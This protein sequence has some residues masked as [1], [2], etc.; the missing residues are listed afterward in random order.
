MRLDLLYFIDHDLEDAVPDHSTIC[1]TRQRI[2]KEVFEEVFNHILKLC[3][4]SGL[5]GGSIQSIDSAY[6]IEMHRAAD[7]VWGTSDGVN[8]RCGRGRNA[9]LDRMA[10][11]KLVDR[12]PRDYLEEILDQDL[13]EDVTLEDQIKRVTKAQKNLTAFK[14]MRR[15]KY[16]ERDGG[17]KKHDRYE[18]RSG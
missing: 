8:R 14:E 9:S 13:T 2:P 4:G 18:P 12:D 3:V 7:D 17:K 11:I 15:K 16:S 6:M 10:E 5:V 1:K